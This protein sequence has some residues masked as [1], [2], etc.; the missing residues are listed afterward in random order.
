LLLDE[1]EVE[2]RH[3]DQNPRVPWLE[4]RERFPHQWLLLEATEAHS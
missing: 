3:E 1:I 2:R 4:I